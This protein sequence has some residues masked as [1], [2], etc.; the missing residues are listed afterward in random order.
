MI[1]LKIFLTKESLVQDSSL[2]NLV[3]YYMLLVVCP[4]APKV[5]STYILPGDGCKYCKTSFVIAGLSAILH[6]SAVKPLA[7]LVT[8]LKFNQYN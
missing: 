6:C 4:P 8:K 1:N 2:I 7:V 5:I 3:Q